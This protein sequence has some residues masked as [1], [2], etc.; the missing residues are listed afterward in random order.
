ML[1]LQFKRK[2]TLILNKIN[3][4]VR[5]GEIFGIVGPNGAGKTTILKI[6]CHLT[7]PTSGTVTICGFDSEKDWRR[8][9]DRIGYCISEERSFFWR[10]TGKQ[11]LEFFANLLEVPPAIAKDRIDELLNFLELE[12]AANDRFVNYSSGMKQKMA[13]ARSLISDPHVLLMD[14]PTRGLDPRGASRLRD[15]IKEHVAD[16][17]KTAIVTTN[18]V[19]DIENLCQR[20]AILNHGRIIAT[21]TIPEIYVKFKNTLGLDDEASFE[22]IFKKLLEWDSEKYKKDKDRH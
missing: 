20:I 5:E 22:E 18:I 9:I 13:V 10:L 6:L 2:Q 12:D 16:N 19:S 1:K 11:N 15:F 21:G 3:F 14:E 4:N 17:G 7:P 8:I